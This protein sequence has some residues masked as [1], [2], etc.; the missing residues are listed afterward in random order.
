MSAPSTPS[1]VTRLL[2]LKDHANLATLLSVV[3]AVVAAIHPGFSISNVLQGVAVAAAGLITS[4][5][6]FGKHL[7]AL[8]PKAVQNE[9]DP[10]AKAVEDVVA[11]MESRILAAVAD[12]AKAVEG[13][14][15][16]PT[17]APAPAPASTRKP[18]AVRATTRRAGR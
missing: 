13:Q 8:V 16:P 1:L 17:P 6:I 10:V 18:A 7:W 11:G 5:N 9:V 2:S 14:Q 4:A 12:V 3:G 15:N